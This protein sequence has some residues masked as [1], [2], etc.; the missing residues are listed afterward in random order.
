V[1]PNAE[2]TSQM[3]QKAAKIPNTKGHV[4]RD[5]SISS[6]AESKRLQGFARIQK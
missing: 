3:L 2:L 1:Q 4:D 6:A 5:A